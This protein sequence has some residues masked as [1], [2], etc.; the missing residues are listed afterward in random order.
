MARHD[1]KG[2]TRSHFA[3]T[4]VGVETGMMKSPAWRHLEGDSIK[5]LLDI[6]GRTK[7][8]GSNNGEVSYSTREAAALLG[9]T[10]NTAAKRFQQLVAHGFLAEVQKGAFSVKHRVATTWRLTLLPTVENGKLVPATRDYQRWRPP[11]CVLELLP[12]KKNTVSLRDTNGIRQRYR[13]HENRPQNA[14]TVSLRDTETRPKRV[15]TVSLRDT[16]LDS[17]IGTDAPMSIPEAMSAIASAIMAEISD[18]PIEPRD[19]AAFSDRS[20]IH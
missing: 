1:R 15:T 7:H 17:A 2:R 16:H 20:A 6:M 9:S 5:L 18:E 8:D 13:D 19:R 4:F 14:P 11:V 12:E 3:G 10:K